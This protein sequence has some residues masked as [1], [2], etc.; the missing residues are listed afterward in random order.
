MDDT[1]EIA[2]KMDERIRWAMHDAANADLEKLVEEYSGQESC[3][4]KKRLPDNPGKPPRT[5]RKRA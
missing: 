5:A 3:L 4:S 2:E 1:M